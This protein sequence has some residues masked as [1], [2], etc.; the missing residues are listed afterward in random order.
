MS[1]FT[2]TTKIT[3]SEAK[4]NQ[5]NLMMRT[6]WSDKSSLN[7][8]LFS[9]NVCA[10]ADI[11]DEVKPMV[12]RWVEKQDVILHRAIKLYEMESIE[13]DGD[14]KIESTRQVWGLLF[15]YGYCREEA[16]I[17]LADISSERSVNLQTP[18]YDC[19]KEVGMFTKKWITN[20][21]DLVQY[22]SSCYV[23]NDAVTSDQLGRF[24]SKLEETVRDTLRD[25]RKEEKA[26]KT[27]SKAK[28]KKDAKNAD[29]QNPIADP[30]IPTAMVAK[31]SDPKT[32]DLFDEANASAAP[33][34]QPVDAEELVENIVGQVMSAIEQ[35]FAGNDMIDML[36]KRV[37]ESL[38][39][40]QT[41]SNVETVKQPVSKPAPTLPG[42]R[43]NKKPAVQAKPAVTKPTAEESEA[44]LAQQLQAL[45]LNK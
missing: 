35:R 2:R 24:R 40:M 26:A 6:K 22:L 25:I 21:S 7:E 19:H 43:N 5:G 32:A 23:R 11:P 20:L 13:I 12:D 31:A 15:S 27:A 37:G 45:D 36:A 3:N 42:H 1:I 44:N 14:E 4:A 17:R 41:T 18:V 16:H 30:A 33:K 9:G 10:P 28:P 8:V 29:F 39:N 38:A 34:N